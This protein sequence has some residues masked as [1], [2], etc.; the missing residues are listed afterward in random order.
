MFTIP[1]PAPALPSQVFQASGKLLHLLLSLL[2]PQLSP[3]IPP[4]RLVAEHR[5][6]LPLIRRK[7]LLDVSYVVCCLGQ[8]GFPQELY[9]FS[10]RYCF[11]HSKECCSANII[12]GCAKLA[13]L[14]SGKNWMA[15][16][17]FGSTS[18]GG[19]STTKLKQL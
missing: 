15:A 16:N 8:A 18:W 6:A 14:L 1:S 17:E 2:N 11:N 10:A 12:L 5:F 19:G 9:I 13:I 7:L 3:L 4:D